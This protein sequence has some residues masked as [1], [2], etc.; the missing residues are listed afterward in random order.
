[1]AELTFTII[2]EEDEDSGYVAKCL[3]LKGI[4]GQGETEE[5]ALEDIQLSLDV[6]LETYSAENI[7][8]PYRKVVQVT[9]N[10]PSTPASA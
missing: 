6:A 2:I 3:E 5:I 8:I 4:Y 7:R 9:K 1:M 10:L